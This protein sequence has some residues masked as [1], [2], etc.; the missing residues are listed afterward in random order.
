MWCLRA[1]ALWAKF[2]TTGASDGTYLGSSL[3]ALGLPLSLSCYS[4]RTLSR[5][6][7]AW[8]PLYFVLPSS[9]RLYYLRLCSDH[10]QVDLKLGEHQ[11]DHD[12]EDVEWG[13]LRQWF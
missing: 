11:P 13:H 9:P 1:V 3:R 5:G 6:G 12:V 4:R 7:L 8:K 10:H 2:M